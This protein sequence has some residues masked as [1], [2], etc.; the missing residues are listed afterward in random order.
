[1]ITK[2]SIQCE[3]GFQTALNDSLPLQANSGKHPLINK[4]LSLLLTIF[5]FSEV[6]KKKKAH[7]QLSHM[8]NSQNI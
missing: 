5:F 4:T 1:M 6:L 3:E 2:H 8:H 7:F